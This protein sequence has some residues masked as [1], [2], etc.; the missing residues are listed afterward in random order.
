MASTARHHDTSWRY[1][2]DVSDR[3]VA[4]MRRRGLARSTIYHR[5]CLLNAW[6][7]YTGFKPFAV[8]SWRTVER[9]VDERGRCSSARYGEISTLHMFYRWAMREGLTRHDPTALVERPRIRTYLPRPIHDTDLAVA[10]ALSDGPIHAA[11]VLAATGGLRCI[12]LCRLRWTDVTPTSLRL[13]GK[14]DKTRVVPLHPDGRDA[15]E[16]LDRPDDWVLP[17]REDT[18]GTGG[19]ASRAINAFLHGVGVDA[20]AHQLRHW[21]AT[22]ALAAS[23]DL[24]AVQELL[25]HA[26]PAT[27]SIYAALDPSRLAPIVEAITLPVGPDAAPS[28]PSAALTGESSRAWPQPLDPVNLNHGRG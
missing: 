20:S 19:R 13:H 16:R 8:T 4:S 23:G 10:L 25:G 12:E 7:H 5:M 11:I 3:W 28:P 17:W 6:W 18:H 15:L 2:G 27:T 24:R 1:F 22:K 9:F 14:G 26:S 21:C